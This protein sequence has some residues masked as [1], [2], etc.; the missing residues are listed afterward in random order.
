MSMRIA[1]ALILLCGPAS[2]EQPG[3]PPPGDTVFRVTATL[4]Q[5]DAE[6]TD[7]KGNHVTN[8]GPDDFEVFLDR[9][10]QPI[11]NFSYV[12]LDSPAINRPAMASPAAGGS[13]PVIRPGDV[14]RSMVLLVDDLTLS[15]VSM[16]YVR[17]TLRNF[18][19]RQ[20]QPGD[21]VAVWQTGRVNGVF[22][23][24]TSDKRILR[25]AIDNL[26]WNMRN[27][28]IR[29]DTPLL[30]LATLD[31][32]IDELRD[33][34][35]RK[36]VVFF[37]DGI[38]GL[39]TGTFSFQGGPGGGAT[40]SGVDS[41][42][43]EAVRRLMDKANRAG[44]VIH[45]VDAR[46][47]TD[48]RLY[49]EQ[50]WMQRFAERTGGLC[51]LNSNG[52]AE[53]MQQVEED[54]KGYYLI[55]F[56]APEGL[57]TE[58]GAKKLQDHSIRVELKRN[59]L[60]VRT[61]AGFLGQTDEA[62]RPKPDTP[63]TQMSRAVF[64]LYNASG[65]H[66]RLTPQYT[67][68]GDGKPVV[69]NLLYVDLRDATF[70]A[71]ASGILQ[72]ELDVLVTAQ[73]FESEAVSRSRHLAIH[74]DSGQVKQFREQG[75]VLSLDVPVKHSG[76][77]QIRSSVRDSSSGTLGS[78]G[79]YLEIPDLKKAHIALTTPRI[80]AAQ[81]ADANDVS[82]ALREFHAGTQVSFGF[83][84]STDKD[85][86]RAGPPAALDAH[87]ELY[88]DGKSILSSPVSVVPVTG[89]FARAVKGVLKLNAAVPPGQYYL[90]ATVVDAAG[91]QPRSATAWTDF[92]VVP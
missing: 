70:H 22:Q 2:G 48:S 60:H 78:A 23:Q 34:G 19:E 8:L 30:P 74:G 66:V 10:P 41:K 18:V 68:T 90:K 56:R 9:K 39:G 24:L 71:D 36:A 75:V 43:M 38:Y 82:Q 1:L 6:V 35:G 73:P 58:G 27:A 59:A 87:I 77:Y 14:R 3:V 53:M 76:A 61:R 29:R 91:K 55:G 37:T 21:L 46:G 16:A 49:P 13:A 15:F 45:T 7:S 69:H 25:S 54:Q 80:A 40:F 88:R 17:R 20:M 26:R 12:N 81:L 86:Q 11:T 28:D 5:I 31:V 52:Y 42:A 89:E 72:A 64:S 83:R 33:T 4:V 92:Q 62:A 47:L 50:V 63:E 32:L 57:V 79:Q 85:G 51:M 84:V 65:I 67:L 44:A